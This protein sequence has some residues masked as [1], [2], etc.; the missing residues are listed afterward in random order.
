MTDAPP[1]RPTLEDRLPG[2]DPRIFAFFRAWRA[3]R[4]EAM[5]PQR[6]DFDPLGVPVLLPHVWLYRFDAGLGDFVCR[7]A[8]E[9][10]NAAWGRSIRGRALR[11]VVGPADHPVVLRRWRQIVGVPLIHYGAAAERLSALETRSAE[12]LLLPLAS[13]GDAVDHVLGISLYRISGASR[14]R[15]PL[16]PEDIVQIPCAEL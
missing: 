9:E 14:S 5:V 15:S 4:R 6:A 13:D 16:V 11:E 10:V 1:L 3:A 7:L 12:R 2:A 8:G